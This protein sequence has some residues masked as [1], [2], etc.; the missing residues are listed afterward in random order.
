MTP[1]REC[2]RCVLPS[3]NGG[4]CP[5]FNGDTS[6]ETGC[7]VFSSSL[8]PCENCGAH[9]PKGGVIE[10]DEDEMTHLLCDHC[11]NLPMCQ[12]CGSLNECSFQTDRT[13]PEPPM[14]T[15]TQRQGNAIMQTQVPNPKRVELTCAKGCPCYTGLEMGAHCAK[16]LGCGCN[17]YKSNW[18]K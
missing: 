12:R 3:L 18:R 13:C 2:K 15:I 8:N 1:N 7:P 5:V 11:A 17:N 9:I 4:V 14:Q 10:Y 16:Q 6:A